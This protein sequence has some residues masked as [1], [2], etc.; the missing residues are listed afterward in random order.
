MTQKSNKFLYICCL[1][2]VFSN[3]E[4]YLLFVICFLRFVIYSL[5]LYL[6]K[7]LTKLGS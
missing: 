1:D 3:I 2:F 6:R 7:C 4:Y 5:V